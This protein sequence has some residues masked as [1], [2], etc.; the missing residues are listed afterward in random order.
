MAER[1]RGKPVADA[2]KEDL[3]RRVEALK[4]KG[5]TPK[6]GIIRVGARPDDLFTRAGSRKRAT[7][8]GSLMRFLNIPRMLARSSWRR[9]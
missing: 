9:R 1:L 6:L 5:I 8:L 7:G 4:A 3:I 2:M